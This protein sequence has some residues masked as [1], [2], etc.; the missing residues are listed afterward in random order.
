M[1]SELEQ[2]LSDI[3]AGSQSLRRGWA[4][5]GAFLVLVIAALATV[6]LA[7]RKMERPA[8]VPFDARPIRGL[9]KARPEFVLIGNS[10]VGTRFDEALLRRLLRP[11]R[12]SVMG[13]SGTMSSSWY[14]AFKNLVIAS[15]QRPRVFIFYR[16][17]ELTLP[18][19]W[20]EGMRGI[21]KLQRVS[22]PDDPVVE[23]RLTPPLDAPLQ[24]FEWFRER[25]API[26]LLRE[27][28]DPFIDSIG[29]LGS[30][31]EAPALNARARAR[32]INGLFALSNL[33]PTGAI[34]EPAAKEVQVFEKAV[35]RSFLPDI[36]ELAAANQIPLT[37]VR[38]R[39]RAVADGLTDT[40][41]AQRYQASL[42]AYLHAHGAEFYDMYPEAW[43]TPDLY[44]E[45][46]HIAGRYRR[47]YTEL[48]VEHMGRIFH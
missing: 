10:M 33:R 45:G 19:L 16:G 28:T 42:E 48:F 25:E 17:Q 34:V 39:T 1:S 43:E 5:L 44:G 46:D 18:R 37:F 31:L 8:P 21:K 12:V 9:Q 29:K 4:R 22:L 20:A 11:R 24:R 30:G 26:G 3:P 40:A 38:V 7:S 32:Q 23:R 35:G 13:M 2:N 47:K 41:D 36:F 15:G 27:K 14:A 6:I